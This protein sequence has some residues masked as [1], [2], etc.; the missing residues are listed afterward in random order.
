MHVTTLALLAHMHDGTDMPGTSTCLHSAF[1]AHDLMSTAIY[2][3]PFH[4]T[5]LH[6]ACKN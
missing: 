6:V 4:D 5:V 2:G 1:G 3:L